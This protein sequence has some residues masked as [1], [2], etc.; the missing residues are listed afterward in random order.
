MT[1]RHEL[2]ILGAGYIGKELA[3]RAQRQ[4]CSWYAT[5][6]RSALDLAQETGGLVLQRDLLAEGVEGLPEARTAFLTFP[7]PDTEATHKRID[8]LFRLYGRLIYLCTS[9][10]YDE[11]QGQLVE[12]SSPIIN[13]HERIPGEQAVLAH[14][15]TSLRVAGIYGPHRSPM[16]WVEKGLLRR[17]DELINLVHRNDLCDV[18]LGLSAL[19]KLPLLINVS[20]GRP[21]PRSRLFDLYEALN[22][23]VTHRQREPSAE[24]GKAVDTSLLQ[25][26]LPDQKFRDS[27]QT[28]RKEWRSG[29]GAEGA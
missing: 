22:P 17:S 10:V 12:E 9:S 27:L 16:R 21:M 24:L 28:I 14:G 25:S 8:E 6:R 13:S 29:D 4:G 15:G 1:G 7:L 18:L 19:E 11:S 5:S 2:A 20:D 23:E 3:R 26:L